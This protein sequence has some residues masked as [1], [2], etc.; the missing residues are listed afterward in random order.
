VEKL[1]RPTTTRN[2]VTVIVLNLNEKQLMK[3]IHLKLLS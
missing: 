1:K 2:K 3:K